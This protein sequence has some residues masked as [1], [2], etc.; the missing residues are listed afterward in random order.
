IFHAPDDSSLGEVDYSFYQCGI[1]DDINENIELAISVYPNPF[2]EFI[3]LE[4]AT[5]LDTFIIQDQLG[6]EVVEGSIQQSGIIQLD[7]LP[8]GIYSLSLFSNGSIKGAKRIIK[9]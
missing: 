6:Q 1:V 8:R 4:R 7:H 2:H 9:Y 3:T 5:S